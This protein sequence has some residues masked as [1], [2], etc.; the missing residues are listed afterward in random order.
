MFEVCWWY[1]FLKKSLR[2]LAGEGDWLDKCWGDS[3]I[4]HLLWRFIE[5]KFVM[6]DRWQCC[7]AIHHYLNCLGGFSCLGRLGWLV[8]VA[9][10]DWRLISRS[11]LGNIVVSLPLELRYVHAL[12]NC[13]LLVQNYNRNTLWCLKVAGDIEFLKIVGN[14]C[15]GVWLIG[16][17]LC[18]LIDWLFTV[19]IHWM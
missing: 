17:M 14:T 2:I 19:E 8:V 10:L 7:F 6:D 5:C 13:L 12:W 16:H 18:R 15:W 11:S 3:S 1:W 4:G 9:W